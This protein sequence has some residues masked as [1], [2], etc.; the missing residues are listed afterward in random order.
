MRQSAKASFRRPSPGST[1]SQSN[2]QLID[3]ISRGVDGSHDERGLENFAVMVMFVN[4]VD[5]LVDR[6]NRRSHFSRVNVDEWS[7]Q[8]VCP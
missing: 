4:N 2:A 6:L 1:L 3:A 7:E 5:C 8:E